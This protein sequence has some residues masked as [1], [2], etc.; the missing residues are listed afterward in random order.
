MK[1][2]SIK[3]FFLFVIVVNVFSCSD[4]EEV[5]SKQ[6]LLIWQG[7]YAADGCGFFIKI[8]DKEYKPDNENFIGD[9]FKQAD[10]TDVNVKFSF[11]EDKIVYYC[12]RGGQF[13][14]DGIHV[15]TIDKISPARH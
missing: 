1:K 12:G 11:T 9:E 13:H 2:I 4:E 10:S 8:D 3:Y 5:Y 6:A 15:I 7:P 14:I